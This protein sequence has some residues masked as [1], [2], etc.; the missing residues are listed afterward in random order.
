MSETIRLIVW[1]TIQRF[2]SSETAMLVLTAV[3]FVISVTAF[4][5]LA[6]VK[7]LDENY[8]LAFFTS[9]LLFLSANLFDYMPTI[10]LSAPTYQRVG[11]QI[12]SSLW[13]VGSVGMF[14]VAIIFLRKKAKAKR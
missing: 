4:G 11:W 1:E 9:G 6:F 10:C 7:K 3:L 8:R 12:A 13:F 14:I 2:V 5:F